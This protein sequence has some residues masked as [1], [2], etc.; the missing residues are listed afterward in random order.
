MHYSDTLPRRTGP[1]ALLSAVASVL[2]QLLSEVESGLF[3]P[4][5]SDDDEHAALAATGRKARHGHVSAGVESALCNTQRAARE[6][7][8]PINQ[9]GDGEALFRVVD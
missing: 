1:V 2:M 9:N 4:S 7:Q 6:L 3:L 8:R 5:A